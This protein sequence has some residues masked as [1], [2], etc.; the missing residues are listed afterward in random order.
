[1]TCKGNVGYIDLHHLNDSVYLH[2][3]MYMYVDART[4]TDGLGVCKW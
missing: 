1:M 3:V 2:A 4:H